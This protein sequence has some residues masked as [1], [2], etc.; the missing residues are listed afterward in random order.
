MEVLKSYLN[1]KIDTL[2]K[3]TKQIP[4]NHNLFKNKLFEKKI[5]YMNNYLHNSIVEIEEINKLVEDNLFDDLDYTTKKL[6][7]YESI[8]DTINNYVVHN[9]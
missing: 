9:L 1:N 6:K 7:D 2:Y 4:D 5:E 8:E 3:N